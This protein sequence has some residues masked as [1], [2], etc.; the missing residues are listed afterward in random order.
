MSD[1]SLKATVEKRTRVNSFVLY[2][3]TFFAPSGR[4]IPPHTTV[5]F[6]QEGDPILA[7]IWP[8]G[9]KSAT[10]RRKSLGPEKEEITSFSTG[11]QSKSTHW[12]QT[13][14]LLPDPITI[15]GGALF[16]S[17]F[18]VQTLMVFLDSVVTGKFSLKKRRI[19]SRELD[20]EIHY[21]TRLNDETPPSETVFQMYRVQ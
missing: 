3:D 17:H 13:L 2:F 6:I 20:V 8:V 19:N 1:F 18:D 9:G 15:T 14:F 4:P 7:D 12:K 21:S 16:P 5:K 10:K 11:P